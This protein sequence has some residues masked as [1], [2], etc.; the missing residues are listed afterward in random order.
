MSSLMGVALFPMR[1]AGAVVNDGVG[2]C[3][4]GAGCVPPP[5]DVCGAFGGAGGRG[6]AA[7]VV[8]AGDT[9][10]AGARARPINRHKLPADADGLSLPAPNA[11]CRRSAAKFDVFGLT[12]GD[13]PDD[14]VT[15]PPEPIADGS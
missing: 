5:V 2:A 13:V 11:P 7:C 9:D 8:G 1:I 10:A 3:A 12:V 15:Y 6:V 4:G 14:P